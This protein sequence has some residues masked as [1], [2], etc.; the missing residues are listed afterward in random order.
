MYVDVA[1]SFDRRA[2]NP[3]HP[4]H[5]RAQT[6]ASHATRLILAQHAYPRGFLGYTRTGVV[7]GFTCYLVCMLSDG[8]EDFDELLVPII[9][10]LYDFNTGR[11]ESAHLALSVVLTFSQEATF[12]ERTQSMN[13]ED[14]GWFEP[15]SLSNT[16]IGA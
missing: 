10:R 5:T 1:V 8:R 9:R 16:S 13:L 7:L 14:L 6:A 12:G 4:T 11:I 3:Q 15:R 2:P